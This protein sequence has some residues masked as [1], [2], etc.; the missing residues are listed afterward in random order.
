MIHFWQNNVLYQPEED[1]NS[2]NSK[3]YS[4][5]PQNQITV[6]STEKGQICS[7]KKHGQ[8]S[9]LRISFYNFLQ[10]PTNEKAYK[11]NKFFSTVTVVWIYY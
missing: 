3:A 5:H 1:Q 2:I 9:L 4:I 8:S 7:M 6:Q 10:Q 11:G